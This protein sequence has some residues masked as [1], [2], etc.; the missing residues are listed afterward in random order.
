[1]FIIIVLFWN[2][3]GSNMLVVSD[4]VRHEFLTKYIVLA[5]KLK[6]D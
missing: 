1:M 3:Q 2:P 5:C 4:D 6:K